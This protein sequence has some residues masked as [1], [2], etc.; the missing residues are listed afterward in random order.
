MANIFLVILVQKK[1][2]LKVQLMNGTSNADCGKCHFAVLARVPQTKLCVLIVPRCSFDL[3]L[4]HVV[5][6][7]NVSPF[8]S[9]LSLVF[10]HL[11][12]KLSLKSFFRNA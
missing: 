9:L 10:F 3:E 11:L 5:I 12:F 2:K 1:K 7:T 6:S 8:G 4:N